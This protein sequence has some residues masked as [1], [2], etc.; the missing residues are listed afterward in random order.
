MEL[1]IRASPK[2]A[3][4]RISGLREGALCVEVT[5]APDKDEANTAII[6]LLAQDMFVPKS[7]LTLVGGELAGDKRLLIVSH[8]EKVRACSSRLG[9]K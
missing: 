2:S 5:T 3:S 1:Q 8:F 7:T 6:A 9:Q 4:N